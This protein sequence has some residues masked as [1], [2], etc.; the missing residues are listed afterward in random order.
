MWNKWP[1]GYLAVE[2]RAPAA[3]DPRAAGRAAAIRRDARG[4][5][6]IAIPLDDHLAAGRAAGV[7][8]RSDPSR[9]VSRVHVAQPAGAGD[10]GG[11]QQHLRRRI[12]RIRHLVVAVERRHVPWDLGLYAGNDIGQARELVARI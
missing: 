1:R 10:L 4:P 2:G 9:Q 8:E 7:F 5:D 11:P 6:V 3:G 12:R